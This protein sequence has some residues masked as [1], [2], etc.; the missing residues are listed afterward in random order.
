M[1]SITKEQKLQGIIEMESKLNEIQDLDILL[2][3][4]LTEARKIVHAD[5]GSIYVVEGTNLRIKHAQNDTQLQSLP[6][7][8]KIPYVSFSFPI[9]K[10]SIA[11]YCVLSGEVVNITD[12]CNLSEDKP[13]S[14]N[15]TND[16]ET[17]YRTTSM[18]CIPLK[19][20]S[21]K[22][23]GV[24][25]IINAQ[26][27]AG[28]VIPFDSDAELYI[29][30]FA[31]S[32]VQALEHACIIGN[33]IKSLQLMAQ[34]RDPKET[35]KHVERVSSFSI[36]TLKIFFL[37]SGDSSSILSKFG[38]SITSSL[39]GVENNFF[40]SSLSFFSTD[41]SVFNLIFI[42]CFV[43]VSLS[44][45]RTS[46]ILYSPPFVNISKFSQISST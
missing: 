23:L 4:I 45:K 1:S 8:S 39:T 11:G 31:V 10:K 25:Q 13:F 22:I 32:A 2:E 41:F 46:F 26:N 37:F 15:K 5:A 3:R 44:S 38:F 17:G 27:E 21:G 16:E 18:F 19:I 42:S 7:G 24:L 40:A 34:F 36:E 14:F 29:K 12:A 30:H 35:F 28:K 33:M 43:S 9:S 6:E 20:A